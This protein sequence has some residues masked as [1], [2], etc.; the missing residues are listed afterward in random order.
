MANNIAEFIS[1]LR[2]IRD[3]IYPEVEVTYENALVLKAYIDE[4]NIT[5]N[6]IVTDF[7]TDYNLFTIKYSAMEANLIQSASNAST[8]SANAI[9]AAA[10]AATA[11]AK[12][13]EIKAI[14]TQT[15]TGLAGT[16]A[17][18]AYN[19]SD[20]KFTFTVPRGDK[21]EKGDS[22]TVGATGT[23]AGRTTYDGYSAGF[24]YL[25]VETSTIYFKISVATGNWSAGVPFG[26]GDKGDTGVTGV[27][28]TSFAF[29]STTDSSG[30]PGKLD[31]SDTY[32]ITLSNANT[33]DYIV[34]NGASKDDSLYLLKSQDAILNGNITFNF[35]P[36]VPTPSS[37]SHAATKAYVDGLKIPAGI[38]SMWSGSIVNIP[39]GWYLCDGS[40]GTPNLTDRFVIGAGGSYAV[41]AAGGS[42]NAIVVSH[43]H[44][45]WTDTQ[46]NHSHQYNTSTGGGINGT[47]YGG[48]YNNNVTLNTGTAGEHAHNVGVGA[49]G[50][51]GTNKNLPPYYALAY[52][53]KG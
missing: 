25:D 6:E 43:T 47:T 7:N 19:P 52:I 39:A 50:E 12:S 11:T 41:G 29:I 8:S 46:G 28:V 45:A 5:L 49:S 15:N 14:T 38:I 9:L 34:K 27:G 53:M 30:L 2:K 31:A 18:V 23:T 35:P 10:S 51:D 20:G 1:V 33:F 3:E 26:K 24:S 44:S 16:N 21:G 37:S 48:Y 40:N 42:K 17:S 22:F 36:V 13:N 4:A 32:R